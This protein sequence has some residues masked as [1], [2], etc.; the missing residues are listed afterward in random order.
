MTRIE[1]TVAE[2]EAAGDLD[3]E[4]AALNAAAKTVT[5]TTLAVAA[6][7]DL[8]LSLANATLY[9]DAFGQV[10][11]AWLWLEQAV[12]A[13]RGLQANPADRAFYAG[14]LAACRYHFRYALP[15]ALADLALVAALDDTCLTIEAEEFTGA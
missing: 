2:T 8:N 12:A 15:G 6:C 4:A 5:D 7:G 9:L 14:K 13:R 3:A 10:V 1:T 11:V